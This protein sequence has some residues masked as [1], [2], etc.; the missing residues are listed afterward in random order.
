MGESQ[1]WEL[2]DYEIMQ[3]SD[4]KKAGNGKLKMKDE[5]NYFT[6]SFSFHTHAVINGVDNRIHAGSV[7]GR[8]DISEQT[9]GTIEGEGENFISF[10][11]IGNIYMIVEWWD[12]DENENVQERIDLYPKQES[13]DTF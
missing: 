3:T 10:D 6:D 4:G 8:S 5:N 2:I 7:S 11:D 13:E 9:T 12:S 1:T